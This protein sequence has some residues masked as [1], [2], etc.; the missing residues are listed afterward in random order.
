VRIRRLAQVFGSPGIPPSVSGPL[1]WEN[2]LHG[3]QLCLAAVLAGHLLFGWAWSLAQEP[4][5]KADGPKSTD[6]T[7]AAPAPEGEPAKT[8][9]PEPRPPEARPEPRPS[10]AR[11]DRPAQV[12]EVETRIYYVLDDEGRLVPLLNHR[13][14]EI[15]QLLDRANK[16]APAAQK[17]RFTLE[18][19]GVAGSAR[20]G[21]AEL[22][23][24][25]EVTI[26]DDDW[27]R[28]PLRLGEA[29][30]K[31]AAFEGPGEHVLEL[32]EDGHVCW[33]KGGQ[34]KAHRIVLD[35]LVRTSDVADERRLKLTAPRVNRS[36]LKLLVPA[37]PVVAR[38]SERAVLESV[39]PTSPSESELTATGLDSAFELAWRKADAA[40]GPSPVALEAVGNVLVS[41]KGRNIRSEA[42]LSI[43]SSQPQ[44]QNFRIRLP[45]GAK[46]VADSLRTSDNE[47]LAF[48]TL[49][50]MSAI[51]VRLDP[52]KP[53][54]AT[55]SLRLATER[56]PDEDQAE[57]DLSGFEVQGAVRQSG[58][59]AI[60]VVGDWQLSF[61]RQGVWQIDIEDLPER[62]RADGVEYGFEYFT[63]KWSLI[64]R[65]ELR[66]PQVLVE[67][68]YTFD[69]FADRVE[70]EARLRYTIR[71]AAVRA[72]EIDPNGWEF[73]LAHIS[74]DQAELLDLDRVIDTPTKLEIPL[75]RRQLGQFE[76][77]LRGTRKLAAPNRLEL[78]LPRPRYDSLGPATLVVQPADNVEL[79]P[80]TSEMV[81]VSRYRG[82]AS[83]P[84]VGRVRRQ[85]KPLLY[86]TAVA[87]ARFV[88][89]LTIHSRQISADVISQVDLT[90]TGGQVRQR[91]VYQVSYE[92]VSELI[93]LV[94][95][96]LERMEKLDARLGP[97][98]VALA[99]A[100]GHVANTPEMAAM[101][102]LLPGDQ[103]GP[104]EL[105]LRFSLP[106][107]DTEAAGSG[108]SSQEREIPLVVPTE[109]VL[110]ES[111]LWVTVE[112]GWK[113]E[114]RGDWTRDK[115]A[116]E[117]DASGSGGTLRLT[118]HRAMSGATLLVS[119]Q[120]RPQSVAT[121]VTK[122]WI[123]SRLSSRQRRDRI[124][125]ELRTSVP[126]LA[127][128]LPSGADP[129]SVHVTVDGGLTPRPTEDVGQ[130]APAPQA[131][132]DTEAEWR[133]AVAASR[134]LAID[135]G[136]VRPDVLVRVQIEYDAEPVP[137][138]AGEVTLDAPK[139]DPSIRVNRLYWE[140]VM[141]GDQ[142]LIDV[143]DDFA[144]EMVWSWRGFY[145][146]R[147]PT[148]DPVQLGEW[149]RMEAEPLPAG[150]NR[151]LFSRLG[152]APS[153]SIR[154]AERSLI[155]LSASGV[156]LILGL[157]LIYVPFV[158][159][160][161]TLFALGLGLAT[162]GLLYPEPALLLAQASTLGV[163]LAVISAWLRESHLRRRG[164]G[165]VVHAGSVLDR[166][167][168]D[169]FL[170]PNAPNVENST[171]S[172]SL[173][174]EY[175]APKE[176]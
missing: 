142:F 164:R 156:A 4:A 44:L 40:P 50:G 97:T 151:Y 148:L 32:A 135:L 109:T 133:R 100:T 94:P 118:T 46:L 76:V 80:L 169:M 39:R 92:P 146:G 149:M 162:L 28:V 77:T 150:T 3:K 132:V 105:N 147:Q 60:Q 52:N 155:V 174:V 17:P 75:K 73:D 78:L 114:S 103:I 128:E 124:C 15:Q 31:K 161:G 166:K 20:S 8:P 18:R 171:A 16:V 51:E 13:L 64:S 134:S 84:T 160:A 102:V 69:V 140:V 35:T 49:P 67:P 71:R 23:V 56:T 9:P 27:V 101:R 122:A 88:A 119:R 79:T 34:A 121:E 65:I 136:P 170:P 1:Y 117:L 139:L 68:Y 58:H 42:S 86:R 120:D 95:R 165:L 37:A 176:G 61:R 63:P 2:S 157:V 48:E 87:T 163:L 152:S 26:D 99:P 158:R 154:V 59:V 143:P 112:P 106:A 167:S 54:T 45:E 22:K 108:A 131:L 173:N 91:M 36:E 38:V 145:W 144:S 30:L 104:L 57:V 21:H 11:S 24:Q 82:D 111:R 83:L 6:S 127:L 55:I 175:S 141:A 25:F 153:L 47:K 19:L 138:S 107:I 93:V 62:L 116:V 113:V 43:T 137:L 126:R 110:T 90:P 159:R 72:L 7:T 168:T 85:Q 66:Q 115:G 81:G 130:A 70:I 14:Q 33:I 41:V 129:A 89:G 5:G 123:Q 172:A 10:N 125:Y 12:R 98:S 29:V 53:L 74:S 96:V